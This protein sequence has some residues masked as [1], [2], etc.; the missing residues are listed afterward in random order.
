MLL[1][2]YH[3]IHLLSFPL[4][5]RTHYSRKR[6]LNI[7]IKAISCFHLGGFLLPM[8]ASSPISVVFRPKHSVCFVLLSF[9]HSYTVV[10]L[11]PPLPLLFLVTNFPL[12]KVINK[13]C[14]E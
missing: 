11:F 12:M 4:S 3:I 2:A 8:G 14:A 7:P 13:C 10:F 5:F 6:I 1:L 9:I